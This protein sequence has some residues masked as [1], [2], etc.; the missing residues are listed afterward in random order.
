MHCSMA[1]PQKFSAENVSEQNIYDRITSQPSLPIKT[2]SATPS[3]EIYEE[4]TAYCSSDHLA[5]PGFSAEPRLER[6]S[7]FW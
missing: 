4:L 7:P 3:T 1:H 6:K 5:P 2:S